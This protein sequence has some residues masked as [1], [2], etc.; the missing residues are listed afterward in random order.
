MKKLLFLFA[1]IL[2]ACGGEDDPLY[3]PSLTIENKDAVAERV[4]EVRLVGYKFESLSI[5]AGTTKT[6]ALT[7]GINGGMSNVNVEF[8][9]DCDLSYSK[10][11]WKSMSLDFKEG[12]DTKVR[13]TDP[14]PN[15]T[16]PMSCGASN[17]NVIP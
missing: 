2:F 14:D 12:E 9:V 10:S 8:W 1:F 3:F 16:T 5:D 15:D 7:T 6:L 11:Y 17:W 13:I 4:I